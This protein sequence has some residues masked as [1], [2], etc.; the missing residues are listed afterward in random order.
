MEGAEDQ[1]QDLKIDILR[2][3]KEHTKYRDV[4]DGWGNEWSEEYIDGDSLVTKLQWL[5]KE[6]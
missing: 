1:L 2:L 3:I 6:V 5:L 4:D